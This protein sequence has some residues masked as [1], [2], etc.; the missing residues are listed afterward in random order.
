MKNSVTKTVFDYGIQAY[1]TK[2]LR[3]GLLI[4]MIYLFIYHLI[5]CKS[6]VQELIETGRRVVGLYLCYVPKTIRI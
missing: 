1:G 2:V 3:K 4:I 5:M 6:Q